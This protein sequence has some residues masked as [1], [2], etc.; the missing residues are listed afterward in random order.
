MSTGQVTVRIQGYAMNF[1]YC[2][3]VSY[4]VR[5]II[6]RTFDE[7]QKSFWKILNT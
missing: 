4:I 1:L 3:P 6:V 5:D 2:N 7:A